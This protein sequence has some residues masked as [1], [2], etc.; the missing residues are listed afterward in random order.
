MMIQIGMI[1]YINQLIKTAKG[2]LNQQQPCGFATY[3]IGKFILQELGLFFWPKFVYVLTKLFFFTVLTQN[4][5]W[6]KFWTKF[7]WRTSFGE[8]SFGE[9]HLAQIGYANLLPGSARFYTGCASGI[10]FFKRVDKHTHKHTHA[11]LYY[12]LR[13]T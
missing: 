13:S 1:Y 10:D 2:R 9:L 3:D 6:T 8:T 5:F 11:Q 4:K 7:I 12:R